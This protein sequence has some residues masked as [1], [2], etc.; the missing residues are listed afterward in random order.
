MQGWVVEVWNQTDRP[1][2]CVEIYCTWEL[3]RPLELLLLMLPQTDWRTQHW[4]E[5]VIWID[6]KSGRGLPRQSLNESLSRL[7]SLAFGRWRMGRILF[8]LDT[9]T[10]YTLSRGIHIR[11]RMRIF[12][13]SGDLSWSSHITI[14]SI[15]IPSYEVTDGMLLLLRLSLALLNPIE[16]TLNHIQIVSSLNLCLLTRD[17]GRW[18]AGLPLNGQLQ[19]CR[20]V[21][22][23]EQDTWRCDWW[24]LMEGLRAV[25]LLLLLMKCQE[26]VQGW[27]SGRVVTSL[28]SWGREIHDLRVECLIYIWWHHEMTLI[29]K[30]LGEDPSNTSHQERVITP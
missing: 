19:I 21:H 5:W 12:S 26:L 11:W 4:G 7:L 17:R 9:S 20:G 22:L 2:I 27:I 3:G 10:T 30:L 13:V 16:I 15:H 1:M 14:C 18:L 28:P 24:S 23:R 6:L 8:L 25:Q 29:W